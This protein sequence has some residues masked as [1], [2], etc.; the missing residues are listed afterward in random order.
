MIAAKIPLPRQMILTDKKY[1]VK[2]SIL[3]VDCEL[4]PVSACTNMTGQLLPNELSVPS[5][6]PRNITNAIKLVFEN[7]SLLYTTGYRHFYVIRRKNGLTR[8]AALDQRMQTLRTSTKFVSPFKTL[9]MPLC[10]RVRIPS[11][12][13]V[14]LTTA[15]LFLPT[16]ICRTLSEATSSS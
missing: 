9:R 12:M 7:E 10:K 15:M 16:I 5:W 8:P 14:F 2:T 13:A 3:E 6:Q 1:M 11:S 4:K